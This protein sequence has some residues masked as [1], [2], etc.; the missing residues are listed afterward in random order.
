M[1]FLC[2]SPLQ[3]RAEHR[4]KTSRQHARSSV[5]PELTGA[6]VFAQVDR[7]GDSDIQIRR[8]GRE[9]QNSDVEQKRRRRHL[10]QFRVRK[11]LQLL[12]LSE[13][14]E[15]AFLTSFRQLRKEVHKERMTRRK[16]MK[17]LKRALR[18]SDSDDATVYE[19]FSGIKLSRES[20]ERIRATFMERSKELLSAREFGRLMLFQEQ[21]DAQLLGK[22]GNR[23]RQSATQKTIQAPVKDS[24]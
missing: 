11:L 10:E 16:L 14:R 2:T 13:D 12:N 9:R 4:S 22:L 18:Q 15:K 20:E 6:R 7:Q 1:L 8:K 19:I 5:A 23:R 24:I 3:T 17:Q 21:F